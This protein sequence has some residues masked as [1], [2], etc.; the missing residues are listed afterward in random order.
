MACASPNWNRDVLWLSSMLRWD[1]HGLS[2]NVTINVTRISNG[3]TQVPITSAVEESATTVVP[4][5]YLLMCQSK[6]ACQSS[7]PNSW[8]SFEI[9]TLRIPVVIHNTWTALSPNRTRRHHKCHKR[10][11]LL[12]RNPVAK[13]LEGE[14]QDTEIILTNYRRTTDTYQIEMHAMWAVQFCDPT[15]TS[16]ASITTPK[17]KRRL[18]SDIRAW[19]CLAA[20]RMHR[21]QW[22]LPTCRWP[23]QARHRTRITNGRQCHQ[24]DASTWSPQDANRREA[25]QYRHQLARPPHKVTHSYHTKETDSLR[26]NPTRTPNRS[27]TPAGSLKT[28]RRRTFQASTQ[29]S[30]PASVPQ[31]LIKNLSTSMNRIRNRKSIPVTKDA[32]ER[33]QELYHSKNISVSY[34]QLLTNSAHNIKNW[35]T[36]LLL[37]AWHMRIRNES[38]KN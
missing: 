18:E 17:A 32:C 1:V 19:T 11:A 9:R 28:Q 6:R 29:T 37:K 25:N 26:R 27:R 8:R 38:C 34:A 22:I 31:K 3:T 21:A 33:L 13:M 12:F 14:Q 7:L 2:N 30:N 35:G 5:L 10:R 4:F 15:S 23:D 16:T 36:L 24:R 20:S